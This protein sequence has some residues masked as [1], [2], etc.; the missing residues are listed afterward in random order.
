MNRMMHAHMAGVDAA[1]ARIHATARFGWQA[2][3]QACG[4]YPSF[5]GLSSTKRRTR[6]LAPR[7]T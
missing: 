5:A 7:S 2:T 1:A 6:R 4:D 3:T